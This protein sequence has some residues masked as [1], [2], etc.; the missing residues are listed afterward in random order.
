[1][2]RWGGK[3]ADNGNKDANGKKGT[4]EGDKR[5]CAVEVMREAKEE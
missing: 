3:R 5:R 4:R 1:M 2:W